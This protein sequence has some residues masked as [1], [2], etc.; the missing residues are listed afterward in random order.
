[1]SDASMKHKGL[2]KMDYSRSGPGKR[3]PIFLG[4]GSKKRTLNEDLED[5]LEVNSR[6][7]DIHIDGP[8]SEVHIGSTSNGT[9]VMRKETSALSEEHMGSTS[10][11]TTV[12][13]KETRALSATK[14]NRLNNRK[15][16]FEVDDCAGRIVGED[17]Q[18]FITTGGCLRDLRDEEAN[19]SS[20]PEEICMAKLGHI[21]GYLKG[22]SAS[23]RNIL[24]NEHLQRELQSEKEKTK[25]LQMHI[26]KI[27][28]KHNNLKQKVDY[29]MKHLPRL[30]GWKSQGQGNEE[31]VG[32]DDDD[33]DDDDAYDGQGNEEYDGFD[34]DDNGD[35]AQ[36]NEE[37]NA[38]D[39]DEYGDDGLDG[40]GEEHEDA[41]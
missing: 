38:S 27:E 39:D 30:S 26:N 20:T 37:Y 29:L 40:D 9:T 21:P 10:N 8:Q 23:G 11:G 24:A 18:T 22:R 12:T 7:T 4:G 33:D 3:N 36:G 35:D 14:R 13:R 1:S 15:L 34:D 41:I 31:Y 32:S 17:S 25:K 6:R 5:H 2:D 19:S 16:V 28:K